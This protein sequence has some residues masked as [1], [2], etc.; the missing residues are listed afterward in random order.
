MRKILSVSLVAAALLLS[1]RADAAVSPLGFSVLA[2]V[3][4]PPS[5]F[6]VVGARV[7]AL[8]GKH[9]G[10][11]GIDLG[12]VGNVTEQ[13]FGGIGISGLFNWNQGTAT[14]IGLQAAGITNV[15]V[16]KATIV[17]LQLAGGLNANY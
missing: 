6:S 10:V 16:N 12:L 7:S 5:D 11:Y 4:F 14:V 3:Q 9:R 1:T 15:N 8:W 17:G 2:P 13:S